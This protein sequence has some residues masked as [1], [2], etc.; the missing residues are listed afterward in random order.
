[1]RRPLL[2][3]GRNFLDPEEA[4]RAGFVYEGIGRGFGWSGAEEGVIGAP[5]HAATPDR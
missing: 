3:D 4:R 5:D 1:M 2:L